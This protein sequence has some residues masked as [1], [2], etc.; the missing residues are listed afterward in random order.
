MSAEKC[1][2]WVR[3]VFMHRYVV[4]RGDIVLDIGAGIGT[5]AS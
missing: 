3:D 4:G 5:E 2:D 1:E